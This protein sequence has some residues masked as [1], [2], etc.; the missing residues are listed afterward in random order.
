MERIETEERALRLARTIVGDIRLYNADAVARK[1]DMTAEVSEGRAL[2]RQRTAPALHHIYEEIVANAGLVD[3]AQPQDS[4][5][6]ET[7]G[8]DLLSFLKTP[9][10]AKAET[11]TPPKPNMS[12]PAHPQKGVAPTVHTA[13]TAVHEFPISKQYFGRNNQNM[14][15]ISTKSA[16][17]NVTPIPGR[18]AAGAQTSGLVAMSNDEKTTPVSG[19]PAT[20]LG[21]SPPTSDRPAVSPIRAILEQRSKQT[22][23]G[24]Q[25]PP[26]GTPIKAASSRL[27]GVTA[28]SVSATRQ[29]RATSTNSTTP[30]MMFMSSQPSAESTSPTM[31]APP[32]PESTRIPVDSV[33]PTMPAPSGLSGQIQ[34]PALQNELT[35][36]APPQN[37]GALPPAHTLSQTSSVPAPVSRPP[38]LGL[39]STPSPGSQPRFG[40]SSVPR[41]APSTRE[42]ANLNTNSPTATATATATSGADLFQPY[43]P[44]GVGFP[45]NTSL[46]VYHSVE[47]PISPS[48]HSP[49]I[50]YDEEERTELGK[51]GMNR[52]IIILLAFLF[53][54]SAIAWGLWFLLG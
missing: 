40:P 7:K 6:G 12:D 18:P 23:T 2:F 38:T 52:I 39:N 37:T 50:P 48:P 24:F 20:I 17:D 51:P 19:I 46:P 44:G 42:A 13:E 29:S 47:T 4:Q 8:A 27:G 32:R 43:P 28:T 21:H 31:P 3:H 54:L 45:Q 1:D 41:G 34:K 5:Y 35:P 16:N 33:S 22:E 10:Q 11:V 14:A 30:P 53:V 49:V 36:A 15:P 25:T 9:G 26:M